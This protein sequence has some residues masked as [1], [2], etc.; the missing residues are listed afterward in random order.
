MY[1]KHHCLFPLALKAWM[2]HIFKVE[3][4]SQDSMLLASHSLNKSY[5]LH[6]AAAENHCQYC[7]MQI[8]PWLH[9]FASLRSAPSTAVLTPQGWSSGE[10]AGG[11]HHARRWSPGSHNGKSTGSSKP[12]EVLFCLLCSLDLRP[13]PGSSDSIFSLHCP[14]GLRRPGIVTSL[15]HMSSCLSPSCGH[16]NS[17]NCSSL[18]S[19]ALTAS[20]LLMSG[21]FQPMSLVLEERWEL[22]GTG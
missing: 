10:P 9:I 17:L 16:T 19:A 13:G 2:I 20:V 18:V 7:Q 15:T 1:S 21:F 8:T 3:K 5:Y 12:K 4:I 22:T 6:L 14:A 11:L